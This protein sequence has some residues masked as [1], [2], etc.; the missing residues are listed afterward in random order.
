M[1][2]AIIH[3]DLGDVECPICGGWHL[4]W[5]GVGRFIAPNNPYS[6]ASY[7]DLGKGGTVE[8]MV[9]PKPTPMQRNIMLQME[10]SSGCDVPALAIHNLNGRTILRWVD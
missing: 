10:C 9:G 3:R 2:S 6:V 8:V 4:Q 7:V 1:A 5:T